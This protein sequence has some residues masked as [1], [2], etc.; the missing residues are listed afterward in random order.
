MPRSNGLTKGQTALK[1]AFDVFVSG[2]GLVAVGWIIIL[3]WLA[4]TIDT[5]ENGFFL[6]RRIGRGGKPFRIIKLRTMRTTSQTHGHIT[7]NNDERITRLGRFF[8]ATKIDE[9]PQLLNVLAGQ[10]SLVGPRPDV[11]GYADELSGEDRVI[12]SVRPGIT[13][14]ASLYF[15]NEQ[16]ILAQVDDPFSYNRDVIYPKKVQINRDYIENWSFQKD[17]GYIWKTV[18]H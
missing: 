3:A 6:Q 7:T 4:A 1:R 17:L 16:S 9:L 18:F 10:M 2:C 5:G 12:L 11:P 13:G 14:P 15:R 8:R